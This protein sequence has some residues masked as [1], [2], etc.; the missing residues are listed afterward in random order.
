MNNERLTQSVKERQEKVESAVFNVLL[1]LTALLLAFC[2]GYYAAVN[3]A[4]SLV[5]T[6]VSQ[7]QGGIK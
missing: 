2:L 3:R 5:G 6:I 7:S 4:L 1:A